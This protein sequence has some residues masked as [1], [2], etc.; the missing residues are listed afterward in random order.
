MKGQPDALRALENAQKTARK[1]A[2]DQ[3]AADPPPAEVEL[4]EAGCFV[5]L[6]VAC[7]GW[8]CVLGMGVM[9]DG[10]ALWLRIRMPPTSTHACAGMV[11]FVV[12]DDT[13]AILQ[14]AV[15]ALD[16]S[17]HSK[18]WKPDKYLPSN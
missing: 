3:I 6:A 13:L 4:D 5:Q 7:Y 16:A 11:A 14:K 9:Q 12:S 18:W 2:Q 1:R 15:Q 17:P 8:G 10:S